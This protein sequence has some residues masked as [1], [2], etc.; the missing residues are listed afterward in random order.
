MRYLTLLFLAVLV[1]EYFCISVAKLRG[2]HPGPPSRVTRGSGC[3]GLIL[4][5]EIGTAVRTHPCVDRSSCRYKLYF[6][7]Q[8]C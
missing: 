1:C 4:W 6:W 5:G 3:A 8:R 2:R 7:L